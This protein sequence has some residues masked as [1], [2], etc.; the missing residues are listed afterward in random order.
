MSS[1]DPKKGGKCWS[2][3]YCE[4]IGTYQYEDSTSY[5]RKCNKSGHDYVDSC[6]TYCNDYVWDGKTPENGGSSSGTTTTSST[7][8]TPSGSSYKKSSG[9]SG[10]VGTIFI[11]LLFI[12]LIACAFIFLKPAVSEKQAESTTSAPTEFIDT[13][14]PSVEGTPAIVVTDS[15]DLRMRSGPSTD[16]EVVGS[17]PKGASVIITDR[18]GSWAYVIYEDLAGWCYADYLQEQ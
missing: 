3:K 4:D 7:T 13:Q 5:M 8:S 18:D 12:G 2:C 11:I 14:S 15:S 6:Q 16:Y 10:I 17:V 9:G 1:I